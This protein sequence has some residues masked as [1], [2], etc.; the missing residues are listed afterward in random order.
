MSGDSDT[1]IIKQTHMSKR[2]KIIIIVYFSIIIIMSLVTLAYVWNPESMPVLSKQ[3]NQTIVPIVLDKTNIKNVS[4]AAI[5]RT[6]S[7]RISNLETNTTRIISDRISNLETNLLIISALFGILGSS[8]HAISSLTAWIGT[9]KDGK[10]WVHWYYTRPLVGASLAVIVYVIFRAGLVT[11]PDLNYFG[12]AA[13]SAIAGLMASAVTQKIRDLVDILFGGKKTDKE[14][15]DIDNISSRANI[16]LTIPKTQIKVGE[17]IECISKISNTYGKPNEN[18]LTQFNISD[19]NIAEFVPPITTS[20]NTTSDGIAKIKI[21]AKSIG[22]ISLTALAK[23]I[24][25]EHNLIEELKVVDV[26]IITV[27]E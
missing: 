19:S 24:N 5:T 10:S 12:V 4:T 14:K 9:K 22:E 8:L 20:V 2:N 27:V 3:N 21:K 7:D 23:I 18:I 6:I 11:G 17:E 13:I 1:E 16:S 26:A 15:G 25:E